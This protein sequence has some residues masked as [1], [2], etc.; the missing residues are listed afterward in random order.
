MRYYNQ[1]P[2]HIEKQIVD[3]YVNGKYGS[4]TIS[5]KLDIT[6]RTVLTVLNRYNIPR[7]NH[8]EALKLLHETGFQVWNKDIKAPQISKAK[9]GKKRP[10]LIGNTFSKG[11][12]LGHTTGFKK[13]QIPWN[14]NIKTNI[15]PW[16]YIDGLSNHKYG[17]D[18]NEVRKQVLIRDNLTCQSCGV[19]YVRL[20]VHHIIPF[21]YG[22]KNTLDNLITV[23]RN[24]HMRIERK[25]QKIINKKWQQ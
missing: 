25:T 7:R 6:K 18:W 12:R 3:L 10:D 15:K 23:C 20:D 21:R 24:C 9:F 13:G 14:K 2:E 8:K 17:P 1:T 16:N 11:K 19:Q 5:Q 4:V 22:G